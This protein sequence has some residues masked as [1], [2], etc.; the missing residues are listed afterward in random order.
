MLRHSYCLGCGTVRDLTWP[1]SRPLGYYLSAVDA[2]KQ[3]LD[4][5][6]L[7]RKLVQVQSHLIARRLSARREFEDPY[8]TPGQAQLDAYVDVVR[9]VRSDLDEE[10]ILRFLPSLQ[11]RS[12]GGTPP[13][14][15]TRSSLAP[16]VRTL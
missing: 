7:D 1:R 6:P 15:D 11:G 13:G 16:T 14:D 3:Y 9:S 8:G 4:R 5:S 10:L 2:L 12:R